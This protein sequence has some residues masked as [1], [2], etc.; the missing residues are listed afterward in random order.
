M[1]FDTS[2]SL[3][4]LKAIVQVNLRVHQMDIHAKYALPN[5]SHVHGKYFELTMLYALSCQLLCTTVNCILAENVRR[6]TNIYKINKPQEVSKQKI[7]MK[8][9]QI[10][11][12]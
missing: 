10:Q 12:L 1:F 7:F 2:S 8:L 3:V 6:C 5:I 4:K 9:I 11:T